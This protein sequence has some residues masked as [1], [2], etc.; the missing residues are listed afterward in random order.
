MHFVPWHQPAT[1]ANAVG[2]EV[3]PEEG[4]GCVRVCVGVSVPPA[5][6]QLSSPRQGMEPGTFLRE[7]WHVCWWENIGDQVSVRLAGIRLLLNWLG[8]ILERRQSGRV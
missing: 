4:Y 3:R 2:T 1:L 5:L 8:R 7:G 6:V